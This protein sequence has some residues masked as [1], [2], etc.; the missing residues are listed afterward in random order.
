[1]AGGSW[2]TLSVTAEIRFA[3]LLPMTPMNPTPALAEATIE[4][5]DPQVARPAVRIVRAVE[6]AML[7]AA[8]VFFA[9]HFVHLEADFPNRSA[10][11]DWSKYTDEG[12]YSL[13]A[14][15]HFQL[16]HWYLPGDFNPAA[17]VPA[18]PAVEAV[19][20]R[21]AG[22]SLAA[23]RGLA[24]VLFGLSLVCCYRLM[25]RWLGL[26]GSSQRPSLAPA[27]AVLLVAV[28][29]LDY[30]FSRL[31]VL[32]P[33]LILLTLAALLTAS[34]AGEASVQAEQAG[35]K[36]RRRLTLRGAAWTVVLGLLLTSM[37][38]T[39]TTGAFLIPA[40]FWMLWTASGCRVR[41]FL[42]AAAVAGSVG[43]A[44]WGG[45][46]GFFVRP[47]YLAD[48]RYLFEVN[49]NTGIRPDIFWPVL[50]SVLLGLQWIGGMLVVL[51]L[52]AIAG[53]LVRL[54][55][56]NGRNNLGANPLF[57]TLLVWIVGYSAFLVYHA[58][59][60]PR[61]Y[62]VLVV[63]ISML[64]VMFFEP[65]VVGAFW[66]RSQVEAGSTPTAGVDGLLLRLPALAAG[67]ALVFAV[68]SGARE[69]IGFVRHPEYT[70]FNAAEQIRQAIAL[71]RGA[72][73]A[74]SELVLSISGAQLSL[75]TGLESICD[76]FGTMELRE[77]VA[78]YKPGWFATWNYV[79]DDKMD[80]LAPAYR[81]V[82]VGAYPALDDPE[83]NLLILYR[84]DA[85]GAPGGGE[86]PSQL[87]H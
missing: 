30:A 51:A 53:F 17:A 40:I 4:T 68:V 63:P 43:A 44:V 46:F 66:G 70:Y 18:W 5:I 3:P 15:R 41:P 42:R 86:Q 52:I 83:R 31:A 36:L 21:F 84:L 7:L 76:D 67:V 39:K 73:P 25:R 69:T 49:T 14:I 16:G 23:A 2:Y 33:L 38:L 79:E 19:V 9:L 13:A 28:N 26:A 6:A 82:R 61:Y 34:A 29:P 37:V 48:Y 32:E 71:E 54:G 72:D 55:A 81:L 10:W 45:Y 1:V 65:L 24:V 59:P 22:V 27:L 85:I 78:T 12:W 80:A 8:A 11:P 64:V 87:R 57:G 56:K 47:H 58:N 35:E 62:V 60:S 74:H 20:F 75:V 77:R 50:E